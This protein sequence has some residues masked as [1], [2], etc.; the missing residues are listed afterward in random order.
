MKLKAIKNKI[1][2]NLQ[3]KNFLLLLGFVLLISAIFIINGKH[4]RY[5]DEFD[6]ILGGKF[7]LEGKLIYKDWFSHHGPFSYVVAAIVNLFSFNS[8]VLFRFFYAIFL[9]IVT[10]GSFWFIKSRLKSIQINFYL[11]F[12]FFLALASTYFWGQML[13]A[14][15]LSAFFILPVFALVFLKAFYNL[16]LEIKDY[17][18]ISLF[19]FCALMSAL[20]YAY[21]IAGIMAFV[22]IYYFYQERRK[23]NIIFLFKILAILLAPY[24]LFFVY[25]LITGSLASYY[26]DAIKF[27]RDYYIYYPGFEG[28]PPSN[29]IRYAIVMLQG[30]H[31]N[32]SSMMLGVRDFNFTYPFNITLGVANTALAIY[33]LLKKKYLIV[34]L[35]VGVLVYANARTNPFTSAETDY[36]SAV[37]IIISLFNLCFVIPALYKEINI[38]TDFAKKAILTLLLI[39]VSVYSFFCFTFILRKFSYKSYDKYMGFASSIYDGPRIAPVINRIVPEENY[40]W[41]GPF[42]YEDLYYLNTK[43]PTKY[44][45]LLP[46]MG[47]SQ[48]IPSEILEDFNKNKSDVIY[49]DKDY[50]ILGANPAEYGKFF[51]DYLNQNYS[52]LDEID[53]GAYKYSDAV[54]RSFLFEQKLFIRKEKADE[55]IERLKTEGL[56]VNN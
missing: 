4:E 11:F 49:F 38:T 48:K 6:N 33:L 10:F 2:S 37:Y 24:V 40:A 27:N 19:S 51:M 47:K 22:F 45:V 53:G 31:N 55:I 23:A 54:D 29:P 12:I 36:Q 17:V 14:D 52:T 30:F 56:I 13:L 5:P 9:L 34:L 26:Y 32:F 28:K 42:A 35:L 1:I 7:L 18:F 8:F 3:D 21:L 41:I 16:K 46:G 44:Q 25:L 20:T 50:F 43:I 15:N 39:L